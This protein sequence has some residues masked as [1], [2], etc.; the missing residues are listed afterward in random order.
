M[1]RRGWIITIVVAVLVLLFLCLGVVAMLLVAVGETSQIPRVSGPDSVAV[2]HIEGVIASSSDGGLLVT[3]T[4]ATPETIIKQIREANKDNRVGAILLRIDSPGGSAAASQEIYRE[5]ERSKKP[6]VASIG[7]VGASG[8][9]YIATAADEIVAS[10]A[11]VVGSIG[12][13]MTVTNLE[14][15][16]KKLGIK[17]IVITKGKYKDIGSESRPMTDEE[18]KVLTDMAT[19]IYEQ[20]IDDVA[21]GRH[22]PR[23]KVA[24]LATGLFWPGSQ[25]K[26]L[27]LVDQMGNYQDAVRIAGKLGKIEGEPKVISYDRPSFWEVLTQATSEARSPWQQILKALERAAFPAEQGISR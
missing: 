16:Y 26:E 2:I 17:F 1:K 8:G 27:G 12:V 7:D 23:Q 21:E 9:Y 6:V 11:S 24:E 5:I 25:A 14:E 22:M 20:F 15:L 13:I 18:R 4:A 3:Q 10:P 19:I